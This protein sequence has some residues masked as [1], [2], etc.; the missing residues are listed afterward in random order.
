MG[1]PS[2]RAAEAAPLL[3]LNSPMHEYTV[4]VALKLIRYDRNILI[5]WIYVDRQFLGFK[6]NY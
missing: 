4:S 6:L 5:C 3:D 1:L 2:A